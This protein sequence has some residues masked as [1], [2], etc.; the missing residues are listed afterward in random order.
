[1]ESPGKLNFDNLEHSFGFRTDYE[2]RR[3]SWLFK[4]LSYPS[5]V[6]IGSCA[7]ENALKF[8]LP[9]KGLIR[10]TIYRHFCGGE[11]ISDCSYTIAR[12]GELGVGSILD[13]SV[14][15]KEDEVEFDHSCAE[16]IATV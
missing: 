9:I 2:I 1:M 3:A 11:D 12:L 16:N 4:V 8:H 10:K 6:K 7:A 15:G 13:Y 14:E 5:V